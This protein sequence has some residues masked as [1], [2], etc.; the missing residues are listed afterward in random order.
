VV[1][2]NENHL[3]GSMRLAFTAARIVAPSAQA[4]TTSPRGPTLLLTYAHRFDA[5]RA[6][7]AEWAAA[8]P[9]LVDV[10]FDNAAAT[11]SPAHFAYAL[12]NQP[13][14]AGPNAPIT[15]P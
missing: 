5:L 4:A 1:V 8:V 6:S 2:S 7:R 13:P 9:T 3:A 15:A 12:V 10:P 14:T 11:A